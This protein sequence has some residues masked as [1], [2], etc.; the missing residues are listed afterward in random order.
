M[1]KK[2]QE[3]PIHVPD[4]VLKGTYSNNVFIR[5]TGAEFLRVLLRVAAVRLQE[6]A[7]PGRLVVDVDGTE[8]EYRRRI[9]FVHDQ[10]LTPASNHRQRG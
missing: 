3:I 10:D 9:A 5:H 6:T 4:D 2:K 1:E 7:A 8:I